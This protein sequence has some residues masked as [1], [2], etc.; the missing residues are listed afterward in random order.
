MLVKSN[1]D[2]KTE[3]EQCEHLQ[4]F[5]SFALGRRPR[6]FCL[7]TLVHS[8]FGQ[9]ASPIAFTDKPLKDIKECPFDPSNFFFVAG[10]RH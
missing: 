2:I 1:M 3:T 9:G 5:F 6:L 4:E 10:T 7:S 8:W